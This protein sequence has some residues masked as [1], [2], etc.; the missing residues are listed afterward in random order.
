MEMI[1]HHDVTQQLSAIADDRVLEPFDQPA[2]VRIVADDLLPGIAPSHHVINGTLKFDPQSSWH[3]ERL[4]VP[5]TGCQ[6]K[7]KN[8]V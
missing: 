1:S 5:K 7:T 4:N 8:Q 3:V 2:S 6:A